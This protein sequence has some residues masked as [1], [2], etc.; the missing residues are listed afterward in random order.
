MTIGT[1]ATELG[2]WVGLIGSSG[3]IAAAVLRVKSGSRL[4][5]RLEADTRIYD[6]LPDGPAKRAIAETLEHEATL[7]RDRVKGGYRFTGPQL[8]AI[9]GMGAALY[10]A[11]GTVTLAASEHGWLGAKHSSSHGDRIANGVGLALVFGGT[12]LLALFLGM[13]T[14]DWLDK[15]AQQAG[16][17][18]IGPLT[19]IRAVRGWRR[20]RRSQPAPEGPTWP[21]G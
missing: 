8:G 14:F 19:V 1:T 9:V 21:Q 15:K 10:G 2:P 16:V 5:S 7:L 20:R 18:L 13:M 6:A 3:A 17:Q 11:F 4:R 12:G